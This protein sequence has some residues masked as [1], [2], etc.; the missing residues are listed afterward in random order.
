MATGA[1]YKI[2]IDVEVSQQS[3]AKSLKEK[4]KGIAPI[5]IKAK[6]DGLKKAADDITKVK[7]AS[8]KASKEV[9]TLGLTF[10]VANEIFTKS[11]EAIKSLVG[12]IFELDSAMIEFRKVSDL[13]GG[14]LDN[15]ID[16]LN[17]LGSTVARTGKPSRSE[18]VC[19]DG[20]VA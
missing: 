17:K 18:P 1:N 13:Q 16:K 3:L 10:N 12:Q 14:A 5:E 15:Y 7:D 2:L 9:E 20:K 11:T 6:S 19:Y 4:A 8:A